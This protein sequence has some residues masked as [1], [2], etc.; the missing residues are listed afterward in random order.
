MHR[1]HAPLLVLALLLTACGFLAV[2]APTPGG[3]GG[4]GADPGGGANKPIGGGGGI[5]IP[6][7]ND[8]AK[9]ETPDPTIVDARPV[10]VDH[11]VIGPDG[12]SVVVY[13]WGGT[14]NCFGLHSVDVAVQDGVPVLTVNEGTLP[15]AVGK[16]CTMEALLKSALVTL[17]AP[18]LGDLVGGAG[19]GEPQ[20]PPQP[21]AVAVAIGVQN[22]IPHAVTGYSLAADGVTLQVYYVGGTDKCYALAEAG[23][24]VEDG[25][26]VVSIKEG[27]LPNAGVCDDIGV[28]KVVTIT[29]AA[30]LLRDGAQ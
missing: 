8:G 9:R 17:D 28:A 4:S 27:T 25:V 29:L 12:R 7:P 13:W 11:W 20:L 10:A 19:P 2:P 23:A 30:P 26:L 1:S 22:P 24:A 3:G 16:A 5:V 6:A 14:T 21:Q 18:I 15:E